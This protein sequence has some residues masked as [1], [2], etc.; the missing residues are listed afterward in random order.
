MLA[1]S[2]SSTGWPARPAIERRVPRVDAGGDDVADDDAPHPARGRVAGRAPAVAD[3][4]EERRRGHVAHREVRDGHVLDVASVHRLQGEAARAVEDAVGD[5]DVPEAAARLGAELDAAGRAVAVGRPLLRPAEGAREERAE[6]VAA[7]L[8]VRDRHVLGG[9]RHA[10]GVR[11][12]QDDRIVVRRVDGWCSR[13]ARCGRRRCRGRRGWCR[14]RG[15][16][17]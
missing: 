6:V 7:D 14:S 3:P 8:A 10:E 4:Q 16:R 15:R 1:R 9:P 2:T 5:G 17:S 12:L 11:A 13:C